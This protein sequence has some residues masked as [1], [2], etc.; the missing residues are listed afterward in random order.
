MLTKIY[1]YGIPLSI[2]LLCTIFRD[3]LR[4][5]RTLRIFSGVQI[6]NFPYSVAR[7]YNKILNSSIVYK[8]LIVEA[9]FEMNQVDK[10]TRIDF[11]FVQIKL[12]IKT[13]LK[14]MEKLFKMRH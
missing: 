11:R 3:T 1:I 7:Q 14:C 8:V 12:N 2:R 4:E 6:A 9:I 10:L 13:R 5:D